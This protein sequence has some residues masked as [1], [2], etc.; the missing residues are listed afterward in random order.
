MKKGFLFFFK[1]FFKSMYFIFGCTG[2]HCCVWAFW[3]CREGGLLS[4]CSAQASHCSGFFCYGAQAL[5]AWP[6]VA[7]ACGF[8]SC[9]A[10]LWSRGSAAWH[11]GL[12]APQHVESSQTRDQ[13]LVTY[14]DRQIR[15]RRTTREVF[16]LCLSIAF[17]FRIKYRKQKVLRIIVCN[18]YFLIN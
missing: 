14:T 3:S 1:L 10:R 8:S 17:I 15:S 4:S 11:V 16:L 7:A 5:C 9:S 12:V 2:F 13:T 18:F 6:A